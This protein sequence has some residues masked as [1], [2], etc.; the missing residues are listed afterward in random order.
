MALVLKD[1]VKETSTSIGTGTITLAGSPTGFRSFADI[2]N[3]NTTYYTI[4]GNSEWEVG[5]GT[6]TASGTTLS[7]DTVL[8][9]SLGTTALINFSA[10]SK[11]VFVTYPS[12]KA[13][14]GDISA[15]SSTGTGS[16]VLS[17]SP[18][19][20]TK[21][22][23][24]SVTATTND[25]TLSAIST[26]AVN[27]NTA[28]GTQFKALNRA[29]ADIFVQA[30]G[31]AGSISRASIGAASLTGA[32]SGFNIYNSGSN[33]IRFQTNGSGVDEQFVILNTA[34]AV[35]YVQVTGNST[36]NAPSIT[37]QGSDAASALVIS[38][39]GA[40][41][42]SFWSFGSTNRQFVINGANASVN[43]HQVAGSVAGQAPIYSVNGSDTNI[44]MAFQPKGTGA[45]DL[46]AGSSGVNISNGGTVTALTTTNN[47]SSYTTVPSVVIPAPTTAGGVQATATVRV[48]LA[49]S[50]ASGGTGYTIGDVLTIVGGT[51]PTSFP[52]QA[53]VTTV[54]GGVITGISTSAS[55]DYSVMP[56]TPANVTGGTG[57]S[58]TFNLSGFI[59]NNTF[60]ITAA[61]S[62][63]IEQPTVTFSGG[64]GSGA[65]AYATVGGTTTL[66]GLGTT[67]DFATSSG[68]GLRVQDS[69]TLS[70]NYLLARGST[71]SPA[72]G[73]SAGTL[74]LFGGSS[75]GI[76][77]YSNNY[78]NAQFN[79]AHTASAVNYVQV[80]G[81]ATGGFPT[82]TSQGSDTNLS[83]GFYSKG[84]GG[85]SFRTGTGAN[86]AVE[87]TDVASSVNRLQLRGAIA[88][89]A[90]TVFVD[91]SDTNIDLALT[92]KGTGNVRFGTYTGTILTP[93][94]YIEV[95][96]SDGTVRRLLVG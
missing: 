26:G 62:G 9:N 46:A 63:Y 18:T 77:F 69:G 39:K 44:S 15:I 16:V 3:G 70:T 47:G 38:S 45:I 40:G 6:Y 64:G 10:G 71:T 49:L 13:I 59:R 84:T 20:T 81:S 4:A 72:F 31:G 76:A 14:L 94:G 42:I 11:D 68:T 8:S 35:N 80:T 28:G 30:Q 95:K 29:S 33:A 48:S 12:G 52:A 2:G 88:G 54:S 66:K 93:T 7:R 53:T 86:R 27:L 82:I 5:L 74:V 32:T 92:P 41:N 50:I 75:Q 51:T 87:I 85:F 73:A 65:A 83:L 17:D 96:T 67:M 90:P 37:A 25:L 58:A 89:S 60:T 57:S 22:T 19:F 1:R 34:S 79:I 24:P 78:T 91:G 55:G 56:S 36:G 43:Y 21:I 23:T 61:G